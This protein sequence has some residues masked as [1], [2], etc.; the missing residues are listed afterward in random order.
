MPMCRR[1]I[2]MLYCNLV[3]PLLLDRRCLG[4]G[5]SGYSI[6]LFTFWKDCEEVE[7]CSMRY[8]FAALFRWNNSW[9]YLW[10]SVEMTPQEKQWHCGVK[11]H[12]QH[13]ISTCMAS[14]REHH[15]HP[16]GKHHIIPHPWRVGFCMTIDTAGWHK[17]L[18]PDEA[19]RCCMVVGVVLSTIP[20]VLRPMLRWGSFGFRY[21]Q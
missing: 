6:L 17:D 5:Y 20:T 19:T 21:Q 2:Y 10:Y 15:R 16:V 8:Y 13:G 18:V 12:K 4:W 9:N 14:P 11:I 3:D 1:N 7:F